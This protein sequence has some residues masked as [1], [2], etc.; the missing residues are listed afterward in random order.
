MRR[1][2]GFAVLFASLAAPAAADTVAVRTP[3]VGPAFAGDLV[4]WGEESP[5][6]ATLVKIGAPGRE[7]ALVHRVAPARARWTDRGFSGMGASF[8]ASPTGFAALVS[9]MTTTQQDFDSAASSSTAGVVDGRFGAPAGVVAGCIPR[10]GDDGCGSPCEA[11]DAV[12]R[13]GDRIAIG[14]TAWRCGAG[15]GMTMFVRVDGVT[16][17]L[18]MGRVLRDISLAGRYVAWIEEPYDGGS[19]LAVYDLVR[20]AEVLRLTEAAFDAR[21]LWDV[22]VQADGTLAVTFGGRRDRRGIRL[23]WL[24]VSSPGVR[25]LDRHAEGEIAV[26]GGRVLYERVLS[27]EHFRGELVVRSLAGG[28]ARRLAFFPER[29]RRVGDLDLDATRATWAVQPTG[30]GYEPKPR[31]PARIVVRSL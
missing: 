23:G 20:R 28:P 17:P 11:L 19:G 10:R 29:R 14:G 21:Y 26:A 7:P 16:I 27:S 25:M 31:G 12:D 4:A 18:G 5:R 1:I 9:T 13:D 30:R 6:G 22:A 15:P 2:F 24:T 8:A 3:A